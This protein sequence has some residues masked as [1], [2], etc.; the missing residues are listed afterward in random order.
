MNEGVTWQEYAPGKWMPR[1]SGLWAPDPDDLWTPKSVSPRDVFIR[2]AEEQQR[3]ILMALPRD[4][5]DGLDYNWR[6]WMGREE[7]L[8]PWGRYVWCTLYV[9]GRRWGKGVTA[10]N[11][12]KEGEERGAM[13]IGL[14]GETYT[15][16]ERLMV[17]GKSGVLSAYAPDDPRRPTQVGNELRWPSGAR[18]YFY[19]AE[20]PDGPRGG[21]LDLAWL[22]E[23]ASYPRIDDEDR[24]SI[25]DNL[26]IAISGKALP[27]GPRMVITTTPKRGGALL[28]DLMRRAIDHG[29]YRGRPMELVHRTIM[30]NI[31]NL[32]PGY[33]KAQYEEIGDTDWGRQELDAVLLLE[34]PNALWKRKEVDRAKLPE[35]EIEDR[36]NFKEALERVVIGVDVAVKSKSTSDRTAIVVVGIYDGTYY[37]LDSMAG[38]W[39]AGT[40]AGLI[41]GLYWA[42][43]A[44]LV[45]V[46][47]NNGGDLVVDVVR[48]EDHRIPVRDVWA[49]TGKRARAERVHHL[50]VIDKVKHMPHDKLGELED[51]LL[52]F[53]GAPGGKDDLVDALVHA[54]NAAEVAPADDPPIFT[55]R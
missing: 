20:E 47:V 31:Q 18:G 8:H 53:T 40:W 11:F 45:A 41:K 34:D 7:Q 24:E 15:K 16:V 50:Y 35:L 28:A 43:D 27:D 49:K 55:V 32:P 14:V 46:E 42:W 54:F 9:C 51:E 4:M 22:D 19:T 23:V 17:K 44:S 36:R 38:Q 30:D 37:V 29:S 3:E 25:W 21:E 33:V 12:I 39:D 26:A 13:E 52:S 5:L 1:L 48:R 10:S 6:G 2:L